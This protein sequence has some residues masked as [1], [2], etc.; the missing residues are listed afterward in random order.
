MKAITVEYQ[1]EH[2]TGEKIWVAPEQ[3]AYSGMQDT[4]TAEAI[5]EADYQ[6]WKASKN[7]GIPPVSQLNKKTYFKKKEENQDDD[8][9]F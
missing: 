5:K 9:P 8:V 2:S 7:A 6:Q 4:I 3:L 1:G